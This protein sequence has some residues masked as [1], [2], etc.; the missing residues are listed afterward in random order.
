VQSQ[1]DHWRT[2][3]RLYLAAPTNAYYRP[4]IRIGH[5]SA[6]IAVH[7]REDFFHSAGAVHGSVY[8][9]LL[10]DAGFFAANSL[11][12]DVFVLT[13]DFTVHLLRP[14]STGVLIATGQVLNEGSRQLLAEARLFDSTRRLV[15]HGIGTYVKSTILLAS[16]HQP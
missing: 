4:T 5:A 13:S 6:E 7:V 10:D 8:F 15:G 1:E 14:V 11:V 16:L 9:K 2:L 3:E 12:Q